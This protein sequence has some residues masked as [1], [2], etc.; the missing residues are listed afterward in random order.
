MIFRSVVKYCNSVEVSS[1]VMLTMYLLMMPFLCKS[2]GGCHWMTSV[3]AS[4]G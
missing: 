2:S 1:S 3:V 4:D